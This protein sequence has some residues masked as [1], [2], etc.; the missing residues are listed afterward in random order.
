VCADASGS[1]H[2]NN[3][4]ILVQRKNGTNETLTA[5]QQ[6]VIQQACWH[7]QWERHV[8]PA[9]YKYACKGLNNQLLVHLT[10]KVCFPI[11][12]RT[13]T[14]MISAA[15]TTCK[16]FPQALNCGIPS[17]H[18]C[19]SARSTWYASR[20]TMTAS[21]FVAAACAQLQASDA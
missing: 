17:V 13:P 20:H 11:M 5:E 9:L 6:Q 15:N 21:S 12:P 18:S 14:S 8:M 10:V 19:S 3:K 7:E 2:N 1:V 16:Q 4:F